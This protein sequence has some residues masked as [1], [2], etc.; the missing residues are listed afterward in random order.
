V[1][2]SSLSHNEMAR[3]L[4]VKRPLHTDRG[5]SGCRRIN[6]SVE[7]TGVR[8]HGG[9]ARKRPAQGLS[10]PCQSRSDSGGLGALGSTA[11]H[12]VENRSN[13]PNAI[14][15]CHRHRHFP[16]P[17]VPCP[18]I[19]LV[20]PSSFSLLTQPRRTGTS[21]ITLHNLRCVSYVTA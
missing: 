10:P 15:S 20:P 11:Q 16:F 14:P 1:R 21:P 6:N 13:S 2:I 17:S 9:R 3:P 19:I 4:G 12:L 7:G 8:W 5:T 18:P